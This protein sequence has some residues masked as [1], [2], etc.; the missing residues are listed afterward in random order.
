MQFSSSMIVSRTGSFGNWIYINQEQYD[1]LYT[2]CMK[3]TS[4]I[5]MI[6]YKDYQKDYKLKLHLVS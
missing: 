5:C 6:A 4:R 3:N 1:I 2:K